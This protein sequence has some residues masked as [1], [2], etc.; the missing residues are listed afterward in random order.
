M[1]YRWSSVE[2]RDGSLDLPYTPVTESMPATDFA[3]LAVSVLIVSFCL[4][5]LFLKLAW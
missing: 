1:G 4:T 5:L 2:R 3:Y